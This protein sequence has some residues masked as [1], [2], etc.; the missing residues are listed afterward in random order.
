[1]RG[2]SAG[3]SASG[4]IWVIRSEPV[5]RQV[6]RQPGPGLDPLVARAH[7]RVDAEQVD[8]A[9]QERDHG[10]RQV[11]AAGQAASRDAGA[12]FEL[13]QD[14]RQ[15]VAADRV[16]RAGPALAVERPGRLFGERGAVDQLGGAEP[17]R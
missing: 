11:A 7:H 4:T 8:A 6:A 12:V 14:R 15:R 5:E 13:R 10:R 2:A 3:T 17:C 1:M 16:D 9:Q